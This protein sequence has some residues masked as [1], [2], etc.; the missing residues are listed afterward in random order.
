MI[1]EDPNI[2]NFFLDYILNKLSASTIVKDNGTSNSI[3]QK[4][5]V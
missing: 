5:K 2:K 3:R 4:E 1:D